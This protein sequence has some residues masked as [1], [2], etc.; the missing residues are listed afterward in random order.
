[1]KLTAKQELFCQEVAAGKTQSE[2]HRIAYPNNM[3]NKQRWEKSSDLMKNVKVKERISELKSKT[4]EKNELT[5]DW[6]VAQAKEVLI[7]ARGSNKQ[8]EAVQA[9]KLL[10]TLGG[11]DKQTIEH[12]GSVTVMN[13]VV[14]DGDALDFG[15]NDDGE[16]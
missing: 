14:I 11:F 5:R 13:K 16:D 12:A 15:L 9:L 8:G 10:T 7:E 4:A 6:I 2:A 3:T 1:M